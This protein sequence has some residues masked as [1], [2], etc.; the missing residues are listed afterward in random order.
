MKMSNK[1]YDFLKKCVTT[2]LP[3]IG[4][5]CF[6]A[7]QIW[8]MPCGEEIGGTIEAV[9]FCIGQCINVSTK[10]YNKGRT[11]VPPFDENEK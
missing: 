11:D 2:Y 6:T 7:A 5:L 4:A 9:C 3:A 8:G 1:V 10:Q